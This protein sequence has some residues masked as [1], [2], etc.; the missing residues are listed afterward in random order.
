MIKEYTIDYDYGEATAVFDV[1]LEKFTPEIAR[2]TLDFFVWEYDKDNDP[3]EEAVLKYGISAIR[4]AMQ[5]CC[6]VFGVVQEFHSKEGYAPLD[7][8]LGITLKKVTQ[9]ELLEDDF[10]IYSNKDKL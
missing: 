10:M 8:S 1:D 6:G 5:N 9:F 2:A 7:G 3:V 4:V